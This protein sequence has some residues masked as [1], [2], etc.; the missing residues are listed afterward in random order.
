MCVNHGSLG[1]NKGYDAHMAH[2]QGQ[3]YTNLAKKDE[4]RYYERGSKRA[5]RSEGRRLMFFSSHHEHCE[6]KNTR[7][8]H[9]DEH[10]LRRVDSRRQE[11]TREDG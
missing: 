9:L 3:P 7:R 8:E 10:P 6:D 2:E 5:Y 4:L 11:D 1:L